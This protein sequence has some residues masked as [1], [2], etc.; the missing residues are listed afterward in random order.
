[1]TD[2]LEEEVK[3]H[4]SIKELYRESVP[5]VKDQPVRSLE[6]YRLSHKVTPDQLGIQTRTG[7]IERYSCL[8]DNLHS[9][10]NLLEDTYQIRIHK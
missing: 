9:E 2:K 6:D 3:K 7:S 5:T 8:E 1:M 4:L 10:T